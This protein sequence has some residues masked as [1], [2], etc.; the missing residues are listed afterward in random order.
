MILIGLGA[1]LA[2]PSHGAP[3][4]TLA[5]ALDRISQSGVG[6]IAVSSWYSSAPVPASSQPRFVNAVAALE[7]D[8]APGPLLRLLHA[9]ERDFGRVRGAP[10][11]AR[12]I[13]LDLLDYDGLVRDDWPVLPHPRLAGRAFV[14]R[15]LLDICPDWRHPVTGETGVAL[16]ASAADRDDVSRLEAG[17]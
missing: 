6:V 12:V 13:D 15:P 2:S 4:D 14:L 8:L 9:I 3:R 16:L 5:A 10:N 1:N 17:D 11:A 7:S